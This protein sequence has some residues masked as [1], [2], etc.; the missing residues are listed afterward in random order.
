[1]IVKKINRKCMLGN[2]KH[3]T[4]LKIKSTVLSQVTDKLYHII[5]YIVHLARDGFEL[6]KLVMIGTD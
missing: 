4:L 1:M 3:V 6:T 2:S 5:L